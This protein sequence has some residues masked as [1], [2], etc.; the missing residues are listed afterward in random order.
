MVVSTNN[1]SSYNVIGQQQNNS[2]LP[3][4]DT[5]CKHG[6]W[7]ALLN[8]KLMITYHRSIFNLYNRSTSLEKNKGAM[9]LHIWKTDG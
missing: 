4:F 5:P 1:A 3:M 8:K 6:S 7:V 9:L 2:L